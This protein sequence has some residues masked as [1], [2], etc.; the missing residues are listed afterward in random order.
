ME[1]GSPAAAGSEFGDDS[2]LGELVDDPSS[3]K[4]FLR[5][6]G[7]AGA[8]GAFATLV[9]ACGEREVPIGQ[10]Q[11]DPGTVAQFGPGDVGIVNYALTLEYL[12]EAF[13]EKVRESGEITDTPARKL[14]DEV[15]SNEFE[16]ARALERI[17]EQMGRPL[18][19]PKV[20]FDSVLEGGQRRILVESAKLENLG[21]AAYL[22]QAPRIS[23]RM[24]LASALSIHTVEA[25]HAAAFN[26]LAGNR[27][28]GK[29]KLVGSVPDGA[30][31]KPMTMD[32]V[33]A[34]VKKFLP[35][36]IPPLESPGQ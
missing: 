2:A 34:E 24:V 26:E 15:Y 36:G 5:M 4:Q 33:M 1:T 27:F 31:A 12:E 35:R 8:A 23:D 21:A 13:Y 18:R 22:G 11:A 30:F 29:N 17:A 20:D 16:H 19:R 7:G 28:K 6:V 25:R 3:R 9:A 32:A 10:S 14:I